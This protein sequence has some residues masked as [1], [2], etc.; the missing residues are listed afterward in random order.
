MHELTENFTYSIIDAPVVNQLLTLSLEFGVDIKPF[1]L[2]PM[3]KAPESLWHRFDTAWDN[4][5]V[6]LQESD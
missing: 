4:F 2:Q 5:C 6:N 3:V 1:K